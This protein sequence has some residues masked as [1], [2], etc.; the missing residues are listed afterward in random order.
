MRMDK[1]NMT[2]APQCGDMYRLFVEWQHAYHGSTR[3]EFNKFIIEPSAERAE[4]LRRV[5]VDVLFDGPV[6]A[7]VV[8]AK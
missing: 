2:L 7:P 5:G 1:N 3:E 8:F 6:A 4:F